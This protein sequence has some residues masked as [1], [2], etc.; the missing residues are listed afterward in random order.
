MFNFI[1]AR[2]TPFRIYFKTDGSESTATIDATGIAVAADD[3]T[4]ELV[5]IVLQSVSRI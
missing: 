5:S 3:A 2:N 1:S 4:S